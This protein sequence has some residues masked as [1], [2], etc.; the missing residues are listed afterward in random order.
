MHSNYLIQRYQNVRKNFLAMIIHDMNNSLI[1]NC[2]LFLL[3]FFKFTLSIFLLSFQETCGG[4]IFI[5]M[6][7]VLVYDLINGINLLLFIMT[8]FV[9]KR[10][11]ISISE[12]SFNSSDSLTITKY[13]VEGDMIKK[14]W[15]Y[16]FRIDEF[17]KMLAKI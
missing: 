8:I 7:L 17:C 10:N 15:A 2:F 6:L 13:S 4:N 3:S 12:S 1:F 16:L 9:G 5:W 11:D 14:E